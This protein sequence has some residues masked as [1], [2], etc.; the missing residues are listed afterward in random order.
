MESDIQFNEKIKSICRKVYDNNKADDTPD[1]EVNYRNA[2]VNDVVTMIGEALQLYE[3]A[4][5]NQD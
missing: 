3:E 2:F 4:N 1:Q 5:S